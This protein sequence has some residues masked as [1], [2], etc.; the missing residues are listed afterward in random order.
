[1]SNIVVYERAF[2][3][4]KS[5]KHCVKAQIIR[6]VAKK[7]QKYVCFVLLFLSALAGNGIGGKSA[8]RIPKTQIALFGNNGKFLSFTLPLL[9]TRCQALALPPE[10]QA[11]ACLRLPIR[12][13]QNAC[14]LPTGFVQTLK[15]RHSAHLRTALQAKSFAQKDCKG[16]EIHKKNLPHRRKI[17]SQV[18]CWYTNCVY[19]SQV[20]RRY[21]NCF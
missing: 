20:I 16:K 13:M 10:Q 15:R 11:F 5:S 21:T 14:V 12:H 17:F 4:I 7:R 1:M 3:V 9:Q 18:V 8:R 19:F 2:F 6:P